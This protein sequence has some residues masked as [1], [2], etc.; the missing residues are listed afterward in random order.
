MSD[1]LR[2]LRR[3]SVDYDYLNDLYAEFNIDKNS[4]KFKTK[5]IPLCNFI[6]GDLYNK[7]SAPYHIDYQEYFSAATVAVYN[8]LKRR[9]PE[10]FNSPNAFYTY[11]KTS[12]WFDARNLLLSDRKASTRES[13]EINFDETEEYTQSVPVDIRDSLD[14][15]LKKKAITNMYLRLT[16]M[17]SWSEKVAL[18]RM[19]YDFLAGKDR[20]EEKYT[21]DYSE[22]TEELEIPVQRV[23]ELEKTSKIIF[24]ISLMHNMNEDFSIKKSH[25]IRKDDS[26]YYDKF[27]LVLSCMD[28]YPYLMELLTVFGTEKFFDLLKI[29]GGISVNIPKI[30]DLRKVDVEVSTYIDFLGKESPEEIKK[31]IS[32]GRRTTLGFV[33]GT[34]SKISAKLD[35]LLKD[36]YTKK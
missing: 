15:N 2:K 26:E 30:S 36:A 19:F 20:E 33:N 12:S 3:Q 8:C 34:S 4:D 1:E 28:R 14:F 27:F 35:T 18:R 21:P 9:N 32:E 25:K 16:E 22:L 17:Y 29:F 23:K 11:M 13:S 6:A 24:K 5:I 10:D 7:I 31:A